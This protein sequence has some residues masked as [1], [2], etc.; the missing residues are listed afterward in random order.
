MVMSSWFSHDATKQPD[1]MVVGAHDQGGAI[2]WFVPDIAGR[3]LMSVGC[4]VLIVPELTDTSRTVGLA[5][6]FAALR[7][8]LRFDFKG[9]CSFLTGLKSPS[10]FIKTSTLSV[11]FPAQISAAHELALP[12]ASS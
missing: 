10:V 8:P 12:A 4:D 1:C 3:L 11:R 5:N 9:T 2:G 6:Q 7:E